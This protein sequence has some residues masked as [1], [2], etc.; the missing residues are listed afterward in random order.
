[1]A[2]LTPTD[3]QDGI[4][5]RPDRATERW[6]HRP[7][8]RQA[9]DRNPRRLQGA[10]TVTFRPPGPR[11]RSGERC[12]SSA[13]TATPEQRG[14]SSDEDRRSFLNGL[15]SRTPAFRGC[16]GTR[17]R[18]HIAGA[19]PEMHRGQR[20]ADER[21]GGRQRS[22]SQQA[23][24]LR[25][26]TADNDYIEGPTWPRLDHRTR[27]M[28]DDLMREHRRSPAH[29]RTREPFPESLPGAIP[30][31]GCGRRR[32]GDNGL[33]RPHADVPCNISPL[34]GREIK[35]P[36]RPTSS[37]PRRSPAE[38]LRRYR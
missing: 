29:G 20:A 1:M 31:G 21:A 8:I 10:E 35:G 32:A 30:H 23:E 11:N 14:F 19:H 9:R 5:L 17:P 38:A 25:A 36:N 16:S 3:Y 4:Y 27:L 6:N 18:S 15:T 28:G 33:E 13:L 22:A 34:K 2:N 24:H 12:G 7:K 37:R 26:R